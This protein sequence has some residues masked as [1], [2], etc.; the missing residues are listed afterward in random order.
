MAEMFDGKEALEPAP[1][2][3]GAPRIPST[4]VRVVEWRLGSLMNDLLFEAAITES[5]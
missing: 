1:E 3:E 4:S 2:P 5:E